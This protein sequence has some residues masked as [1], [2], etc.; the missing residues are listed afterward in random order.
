MNSFTM[1]EYYVW[2]CDWCDTTNQT[3]WSR[4]DRNDLFCAACHH[5]RSDSDVEE[6]GLLRRAA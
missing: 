3:H 5:P 4:I 2:Y 6:L 1:G